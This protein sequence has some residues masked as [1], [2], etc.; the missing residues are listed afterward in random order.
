MPESDVPDHLAAS[1]IRRQPVE[2][3]LF[4]IKH[5]HA[6]GAVNLMSAEGKEIRIERLHVY[7]KMRSALRTVHQYG[8]AVGMGDADHPAHGVDRAQH[9]AHVRHA[10]D[11][12]A[13][14]EEPFVFVQ[15]QFATVVY[16]NYPQLDA[17][18]C[19]QELPAHDVGVVL[20]LAEDDF[21]AFA[22]EGL[23]EA[24][25]H[26]VDALRRAARED[27]LRCAAGIQE[28][29]HRLAGRLVQLRG[30]LR[31]EVHAPVHVGVHVVVFVRHGFH[32]A[33]GLLRR[34][35]VVQIDQRA[36]VD[37]T[38]QDGEV[39]PYLLYVVHLSLIYIVCIPNNDSARHGNASPP[40]GAGGRARPPRRWRR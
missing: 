29:A 27:D 33:A 35:P 10:D 11:A 23:A 24:G 34:G 20:H 1:H 28:A 31:K 9:V 2:P 26:E 14:V 37:L 17:L 8:H 39:F 21:V 15:H 38:S 25:S 13:V 4:A 40:N 16:R 22:H 19:L 30:L 5:A 7:C 18:A 36:T 12:R 32:H 3:R 6:R